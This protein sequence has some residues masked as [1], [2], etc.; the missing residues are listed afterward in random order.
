MSR[1]EE[2]KRYREKGKV[3]DWIGYFKLDY[4]WPWILECKQ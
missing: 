3:D 2:R 1:E 4:S